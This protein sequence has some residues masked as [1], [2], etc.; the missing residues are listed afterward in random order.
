MLFDKLL[1]VDPQNGNWEA[2]QVVIAGGQSENPISPNY[3]DLLKF[4]LRGEAITMPWS[5]EAIQRETKQKLRL[6]PL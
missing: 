3:D 1:H 5:D 2:N 4:W 6:T